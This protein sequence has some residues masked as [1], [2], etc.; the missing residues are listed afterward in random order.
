[1]RE[2]L[3]SVAADLRHAARSLRSQPGFAVISVTTLALGIGSTTS[4]FSAV[5]GALLRPLPYA[6][7]R[8]IVHVGEQDVNKPG[9]GATTSF[10]NFDDWRRRS[11]SFSAIGIVS[12]VSP[13]L[14]GHGDAER[15]P[16][17]LVSAGMFAVFGIHMHLGRP[18]ADVDNEQGAAPVAVLTYAFWQSRFGADPSIVD[19]S[20]SLNSVPVK[21][22]GVLP[23]GFSGPGRLDRA[24]WSNFVPSASDGRGGRSKEVYALLRSTTSASEA[25]REM[26]RIA[27]D[28][29]IAYPSDNK[30]ATVIVDPLSDRS[31]ADVKRPLYT[32]LGASF[33]VLLIACANLSNL[34][35]ARGTARAREIAVR[36]ALGARRARI[37]RQLLTENLLL[38]FL[39]A[40]GGIII[41]T[42]AI[43]T[44]VALGPTL[45]ATRP[46]EL[47]P[48]VLAASIAV[49]CA[50]VLLF[51]LLPA[52]HMAPRDPQIAL[53]DAGA[54]VVGTRRSLR[55]ALAIAQLSLAVVLLSASLLVVKSFV[56]VLEVDAGIRHENLLTM[57]L[58][59]PSAKYDSLRSTTF[60]AQVA[61]QV[62]QLPNVKDVA[63]TSLVPFSGSFDRVGIS[64]IAGESER[65]GAARMF[66]DRY[67]VTA[68]YF[69]AMGIRLVNGRPLDATDRIETPTV[70]LVDEVFARRTFG[71]QNPLGRQMKIPGP[72]RAEFATIV[73]VVSHVKT[74]GLDVESPGQIYLSNEQFPWR[75]SSMVVRTTDDPNRAAAAITRIVH[76]LDADQPVANVA[77][78]D[79]LMSELLRGRRFILILLSS[80]AGVAVTLAAIGLYGVI[81]YGVSQR[82]RELGVRLAL[83]AQRLQVARMIVAE[84]SRIA[85]AGATIGILVSAASGRFIGSFLFEVK[86]LDAAVYSIVVA[87]LIAVAII[88]CLVPAHRATMVDAAEVLRG[89]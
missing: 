2:L 88:A 12:N 63:F 52:L 11:S 76:G 8:R 19:Q 66:A 29:A 87:G 40:M 85:V 89:E 13:T 75:S 36:S 56:R 38:A 49:S 78:M 72:S 35:L 3:E 48:P 23:K 25:Q 15:I 47:S 43:R 86:P 58:A 68:D 64:Q 55:S 81:A 50:T 10:E 71:G 28:L 33:F 34:L 18:I 69:K 83:G 42:A 41:A 39:G 80:F 4:V 5:N 20:I 54:R 21:I 70:C 61:A 17:A 1:M 24:I 14:T 9:R 16:S 67:V 59:L 44:L 30:G 22:I 73:G 51:G 46:P 77:T 60:Y 65:I 32:L 79:E 37:A 7:A 27:G 84:G 57:S 53:R 82:R 45:F 31:V 74:Y 6:S 62:K 26:T